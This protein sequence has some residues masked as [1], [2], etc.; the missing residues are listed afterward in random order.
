MATADKAECRITE[1]Q[2][3]GAL[4]YVDFEIL[5]KHTAFVKRNY[6]IITSKQH[7]DLAKYIQHALK[8]RETRY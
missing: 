5:K 2:I 8:F 7:V 4:L 3:F 1:G 6:L